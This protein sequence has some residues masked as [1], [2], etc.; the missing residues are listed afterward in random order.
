MLCSPARSFVPSGDGF[1]RIS[2]YSSPSIRSRLVCFCSYPSSSQSSSP[3]SHS[4]SQFSTT[5][6]TPIT[7]SGA[8]VVTNTTAI[9]APAG[10]TSPIIRKRKRYRKAYPGENKGIAE[11]MR[12]VAMR[13]QNDEGRAQ[14]GADKEE[15]WKPSSDGFLKY[16]VD[17][18]LVFET[19][20]RTV[21]QS[22]DVAYAYFRNTGL[23]RANG[24]ANDLDWFRD[25]GFAIPNPSSPG[26]AYAS[27]LNELAETSQSSFLCHF[28]NVYFAHATGG[29]EIGKQVSEKLHLSREFELY[30]WD[31]DVFWL[32]QR[33]REKLNKLGDHWSR[34]DKNTCLRE[35][36]K[37]FRYLGQIV[38][39]II[40]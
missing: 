20:E 25:Q 39:L 32:L 22:E 17:S 28:Y 13:L 34:D 24:V 19:L 3:N 35:V 4:S 7:P 12:F 31:D 10:S 40:L 21:D 33:T 36:A 15:S 9:S 1:L 16:L 18:K 30:K 26:M 37:C 6:T 5:T 2:K 23:E 38:R 29:L 11:E 8:T 27:Y 14:D